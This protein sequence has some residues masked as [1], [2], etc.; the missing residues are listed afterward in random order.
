MVHSMVTAI[1][2]SAEKIAERKKETANDETLQQLKQQMAQGWPDRKH[3][4]PHNLAT[5]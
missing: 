1:P 3:E 5:Y 2:A 4:F